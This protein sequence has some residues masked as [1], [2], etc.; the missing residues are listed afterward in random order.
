MNLVWGSVD[1]S[2]LGH[3]QICALAFELEDKENGDLLTWF[4]KRLKSDWVSVYI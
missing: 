2:N 3:T 1:D 4:I